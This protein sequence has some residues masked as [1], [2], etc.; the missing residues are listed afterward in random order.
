MTKISISQCAA[1]PLNLRDP[2]LV[3][4]IAN[5]PYEVPDTWSHVWRFAIIALG[6]L[7]LCSCQGPVIPPHGAGAM[8]GPEAGMLPPGAMAGGPGAPM[9]PMAG[10]PG[11]ENGVPLPYTPSGPWMPPGME[12]PWPRD[13]YVS[14]GGNSGPPIRVTKQGEVRG[15]QLEDTVAHFDTLDGRTLV[16]PSNKVYVY[17]PRFGAVRQIVDVRT[18]QNRDRAA[19]VVMPI[20]ALIPRTSEAVAMGGQATRPIDEIGKHPAEQMRSRATYSV[21]L[22]RL[23]PGTFENMFKAYENL[24]VIRQGVFIGSETAFLAKGVNAAVAWTHDQ[25]AQILLDRQAAV[26]A[27]A[28][29]RLEMTYT[30]T[31]SPGHPKLRVIK[32]ASTPFAEPGDEVSFTIRFDNVGNQPIGNVTIL[33]SLSTRLEYI[34]DSAQ[35]SV[36]A[37]FTTKPNE[38]D[39]VVVRC[40]LAD[41]LKP[42]KGGVLRFRCRVR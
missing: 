8:P 5:P 41:P 4:R 32:V 31:A 36:N 18:D 21:M 37:Q 22:N 25:G 39:S 1:V 24:A 16:E 34:P 42:G 40:E 27:N 23:G 26:A 10:P 9:P 20:R 2:R 19:G 17:A 35:C 15:L 6:A 13:E 38:G 3:G 30:V 11:M 28:T 29:E 7:I 33:D 14:D 12:P